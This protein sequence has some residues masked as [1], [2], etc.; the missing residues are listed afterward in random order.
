MHEN[1]LFYIKARTT[2]VV[3]TVNTC[4]WLHWM[5]CI[6]KHSNEMVH[7]YIINRRNHI[8]IVSVQKRYWITELAHDL[9]CQILN[10][11]VQQWRLILCTTQNE[12]NH[13]KE[14][15]KHES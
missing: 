10:A 12:S 1:I 9:F 13:V 7:S 11:I 3:L 8:Y 6:Q 4:Q 14:I 2:T 15:R 5:D